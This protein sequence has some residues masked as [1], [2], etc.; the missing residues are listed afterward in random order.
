VE[1]VIDKGEVHNCPVERAQTLVATDTGVVCSQKDFSRN[2]IGVSAR[3]PPVAARDGEILGEHAT[4]E[5]SSDDVVVFQT[6]VD[7]GVGCT[8]NLM[9]PRFAS[10][11]CVYRSVIAERE[12]HGKCIGP[13]DAKLDELSG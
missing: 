12:S 1:L 11:G 10:R 8:C 9:H 4:Q 2:C 13:R 6:Y 7:P 5:L 3:D